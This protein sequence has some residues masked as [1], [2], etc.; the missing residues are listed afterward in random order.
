MSFAEV[1]G[2]AAEILVALKKLNEPLSSKE[3][4][5]L[6]ENQ[7]EALSGFEAASEDSTVSQL[8]SMKG[9]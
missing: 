4:A 2:Q 3:E 9:S 8:P 5:F 1:S 6:A 7:S